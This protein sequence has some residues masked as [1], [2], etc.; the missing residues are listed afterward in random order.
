MTVRGAAE[1]GAGLSAARP[2]RA[3]R[4]GE[5]IHVVGAAGAGASAAA[6][7][8]AW[9]GADVDGCD[10]GGASQYTPALD[11]AGIRL[12]L[13]HDA[14]HL[15]GDR[16]PTRLAVTKALTAIDPDNPELV[17]ARSLGLPLDPWQ[18]VVA[19][20]AAGRLLVAVAGTHGKS[21][22]A[23]WL[24]HVLARGGMDPAA[25]VGAL[26]PASLTGIGIPATARRGEG[27]PFVVEADE[28]AGN[29]DA[30]RPDVIVLTS[31][32]WDHPD[33]FEDRG[34]V[35]AA[36]EAWIRRAAEGRATG[37]STGA[38]A[39]VL[40][41]NVGDDGVSELVGRLG[42]WPGRVIETMLVDATHTADAA[43][44]AGHGTAGRAS[45]AAHTARA[46]SGL[47]TPVVGRITAMAP[48][49]TVLE[50]TGLAGDPAPLVAQLT[51]A[52]RHN[53]SNALGVAAA[54]AVAGLGA[55]S[56]LD[57]LAS[58]EGVGRRLE[59]KGEIHGVVVYDD[60]G[61]HPTAIR[62]TLAAVRQREP[63]RPVWAVYEPLTYHRTAAFLAE[64]AEV[65]AAADGVAIAD[66]WA[67]RDP[68]TTIASA[69]G[70]ARVVSARA[71]GIPVAAPGSVESTALWL[72]GEVRPGDVVLVMGG[73]R[74]YRIGEL[75]LEHLVA[76]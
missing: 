6:L 40:I 63:G 41:A 36:F 11:A 44:S 48:G 27:R 1:I 16:P 21:T 37:V 19:D 62:E 60:Y 42:G 46:P 67:G 58:F 31:A 56:I 57:G 34:A 49:Q 50:I 18:Q 5:R 35:I 55:R 30:Y 66:I 45:D 2:A 24:V 52:G 12:E 38:D 10:P 25:F 72:A 39:P 9:A 51:T 47:G 26:L 15:A 64:F 4:L 69:E 14:A 20:A 13:G 22:S 54:A 75:L 43:R 29:F 73:G 3:I 23:G 8:G 74:S 76:E 17:A 7:L 65:L 33:V 32:E 28:Y 70:L 68:D 71:P 61:H 59:R 53:A